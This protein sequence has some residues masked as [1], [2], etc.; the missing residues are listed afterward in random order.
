[1]SI[2]VTLDVIDGAQFTNS[3]SDGTSLTRMALVTGIPAAQK[4]DPFVL[5]R[6]VQAGGMPVLGSPHPADSRLRLTKQMVMPTNGTD[7]AMVHL[8]YEGPRLDGGGGTPISLIVEDDTSLATVIEEID[9]NGAVIQAIY[10]KNIPNKKPKDYPY[11]VGMS[12]LRPRRVLSI[13]GYIIG[14]K[15]SSDIREAVGKVNITNWPTG[16]IFA[17]DKPLKSGFW[18]CTRSSAHIETRKNPFDPQYQMYRVSASFTTN[19]GKDWSS[20]GIYKNYAGR[21]PKELVTKQTA[22]Q[23]SDLKARE[24]N[25]NQITIENG[26][27][28]GFVKVGLYDYASFGE[29]FGF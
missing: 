22:K 7:Q 2:Q 25:R 13:S 6:A 12:V 27:V 9:L 23:V 26:G 20:Y 21:F 1:M 16:S 4:S 15:P 14:R 8:T 18:L 3:F 10:R 19:V 24:Y 17:G 28:N 5:L 11:T 29:I